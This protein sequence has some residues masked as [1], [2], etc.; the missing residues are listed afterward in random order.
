MEGFIA[1]LSTVVPTFLLIVAR[2]IGMLTQAPVLGS[3]NNLPNT[4]RITMAFM[5]SVTV[6]T[7]LS[8]Y[9]ELPRE[10]LAYI[11]LA[12]MEFILGFLF[13]FS[14]NIMFLA[15][16]AAGELGGQQSGMSAATVQ[17]PFTKT[18]GNAMGTLFYQISLLLFLLVGG[19]LWMMGGFIQSFQLVPLG[20]FTLHPNL[21]KY[22]FNISTTFLAIVIQ[23]SLPMVSVVFVA[24][25]GVGYMSKVAQQ[26]SSLTQDL[27]TIA[28]PVTGM[29]IL[30]LVMPNLMSMTYKY[31][32]TMI[33][34]LDEML[35]VAADTHSPIT[36]PR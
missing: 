31:A 1:Y 17:N 14:A 7:Q 15:V 22:F 23:L 27:V 10:L 16:Q 11:M 25:L 32:E 20:T 34:D 29:L 9:P 26:A 18:G 21:M 6:M 8:A 24:E 4:V 36:R 30:L 28:K 2:T 3:R 19:H 12:V 33:H 5:L 35:R 13:G